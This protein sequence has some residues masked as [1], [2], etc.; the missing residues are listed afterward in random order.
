MT[1]TANASNR[2]RSKMSGAGA[3]SDDMEALI[4]VINKLQDVFNTVGEAK[5]KAF[6]YTN[7]K[8]D[9]FYQP[10]A[11]NT[12]AAPPCPSPT[13]FVIFTHLHA[14][15][16][17]HTHPFADTKF[18]PDCCCWITILGEE[19]RPRELGW[20]G[21]PPA[22]HR[23]RDTC[24]ISDAAYQRETCCGAFVYVFYCISFSFTLSLITL[25]PRPLGQ[26]CS[27][28]TRTCTSEGSLA[29]QGQQCGHPFLL[30]FSLSLF[31]T[32]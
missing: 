17:A 23:N 2:R 6:L 13:P 27:E 14:R 3:A 12:V 28:G 24:T 8:R 22:R 7:K 31:L 5:V 11:S 16:R 15:T 29:W 26:I 25:P 9:V 10:R 19:L 18:A 4:P 21:L 20:Q 30:L 1:T 32:F